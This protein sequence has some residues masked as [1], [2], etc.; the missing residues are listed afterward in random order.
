[1]QQPLSK[2]LGGAQLQRGPA[3]CGGGGSVAYNL[4]IGGPHKFFTP[5]LESAVESAS[6]AAHSAFQVRR[7]TS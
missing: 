1:L 4:D 2:W 3:G 6:T 7:K 5:S